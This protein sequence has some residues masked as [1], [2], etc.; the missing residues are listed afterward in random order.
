[1]K[2]GSIRVLRSLRVSE[3]AAKEAALK[4]EAKQAP[5]PTPAGQG[6]VVSNTMFGDSL[7][8]SKKTGGAGGAFGANPFSSGGAS[9][10]NPFSTAAPAAAANPFST[11][12]LAAKPPQKPSSD[13][14]QTFASALSLNAPAPSPPTPSEPWPTDTELPAPYP[15]FYLADADYETL[16]KDEPEPIQKHQILE[17]EEEGSSGGSSAKED[18]DVY[19]SQIDNTFQK[20][21]DR[22]SQNPEQV[23][24]RG[25]Q[26]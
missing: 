24:R 7:F 19:E 26:E 6:K 9:A 11:S 8:G 25:Q 12:E 15:L 16:D 18:K 4:E 20:F 23:I 21:A 13:L 22:L 5:K 1:R 3:A 10:A 2:E 14:P 17:M